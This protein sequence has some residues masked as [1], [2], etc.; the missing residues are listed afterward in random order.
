MFASLVLTKHVPRFLIEFSSSLY[1]GV[2]ATLCQAES[3]RNTTGEIESWQQMVDLLTELEAR[4]GC[5]YLLGTIFLESSNDMSI[6]TGS[7][8]TDL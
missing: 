8:D 7:C 2:W 6:L 4:A 5:H 1:E 3:G